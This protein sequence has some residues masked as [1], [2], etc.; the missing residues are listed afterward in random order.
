MDLDEL[1]KHL[2]VKGTC[3]QIEK[4]YFRMTQAPNP[5]DIRPEPVLKEALRMVKRKWKRKE[6]NYKYIDD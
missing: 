1:A 2:T 5:A 6:A 3:T 4:T